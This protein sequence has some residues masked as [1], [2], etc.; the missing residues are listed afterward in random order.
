VIRV[1]KTAGLENQVG[2]VALLLGR[3][4]A[5]VRSR[6]FN[7]RQRFNAAAGEPCGDLR[8]GAEQRI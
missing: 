3:Q 7:A 1:T 6:L 8:C 4:P 5:E 2:N